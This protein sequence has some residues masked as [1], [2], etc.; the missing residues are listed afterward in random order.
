MYIQEIIADII[1]ANHFFFAQIVVFDF[2][3]CI[4]N[5]IFQ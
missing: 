3:G 2:V 4:F 5:S 1:Y